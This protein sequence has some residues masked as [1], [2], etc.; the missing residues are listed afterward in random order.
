M[1]LIGTLWAGTANA[2]SFGD[3]L[4]YMGLDS[5]V[6][7]N[8]SGNTVVATSSPIIPKYSLDKLLPTTKVIILSTDY[9]PRTAGQCVGYVRYIT[10]TEYSGNAI[11]WKQHINLDKPEV[12]SIVVFQAG[13]WGHIGV[14]VEIR[15]DKIIVRSRNWIKLWQISDDEFDISDIRILGYIKY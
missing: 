9:N 6:A 7:N 4:R 2:F 12:G 14:V 10:G 8:D 5:A 1:L 3:V 13:K 11:E 15:G